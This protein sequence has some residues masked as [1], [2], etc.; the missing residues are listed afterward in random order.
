MR[1]DWKGIAPALSTPVDQEGALDE[2]SF[3]RQ[4]RWNIEKGAHM[5]VASLMAGEFHKFSNQERM[6]TFV[7]AVEAADGEVPVLVGVSHSGTDPAAALARHAE[8]VGADGVVLL[9]PY[10]NA[11]KA[12][13]SLYQHYATVAGR[14]GLPM[15]IQDCEGVGPYLCPTLY[16][17]L[18]E[19]FSNVVSVKIEGVRAAE[20]IR[21]AVR[22][23]GDELAIFGGM[24]ARDM[25]QELE[26]G[27]H[28][29]VPDACLTDLLVEIYESFV[30]GEVRKAQEAFG[31]YKV[32]ADFLS[33]HR[34]SNHEVEKETLKLRGV[35]GCARTR[36][37]SGPELDGGARAEL[38]G[39]LREI[40]VL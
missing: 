23:L 36:L 40:G 3:C 18:A 28:G 35:I 13:L 38:E 22:L 4:V 19:D 1:T 8:K 39:I 15:M 21:E 10:F 37:P 29:N 34:L 24:A 2:E 14:T 16:A 33:A 9:P 5:V 32:W 12:A 26:V 7:L 11:D 27:A 17:R 20:K 6:R 30:A 25:L 31:R